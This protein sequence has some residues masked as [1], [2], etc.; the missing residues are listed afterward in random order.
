MA[1]SPDARTTFS[2]IEALHRRRATRAIWLF[3]FLPWM[4]AGCEKKQPAIVDPMR[5]VVVNPHSVTISWTASKSKVAGYNVYRS[6]PP[7]KPVKL[8]DGIVLGTQYTDKTAEAGHKYVYFVTSVDLTG[9]EGVSSGGIEATVPK[10]EN[11]PA[12]P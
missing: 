2:M 3:C 12:N 7:D 1:V 4:L 9:L 11:P 10:T 8:T 5:P 6:S